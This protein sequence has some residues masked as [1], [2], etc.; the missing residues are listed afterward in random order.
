MFKKI[1]LFFVLVLFSNCVDIITE[2][3]IDSNTMTTLN[4]TLEKKTY[5]YITLAVSDVAGTL[6]F[7]LTDKNYTL[8]YNHLKAC[9]TGDNPKLDKTINDCDWDE[10]TPYE[11][12]DNNPKDYYYKKNYLPHIEKKYLIV[13]YRGENE[14]GELKV[15]SSLTD[16]YQKIKKKAKEIGK[17]FLKVL[18]IFGIV[19]GC[20]VGLVIVVGIIEVIIECIKGDKGKTNSEE[21]EKPISET[22]VEIPNKD[23]E[24]L[25]NQT[26][27]ETGD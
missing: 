16:I 17:G 7:H 8:D 15:E 13:L 2:I 24:P 26:S 4:T 27:E 20:F 22:A 6:Y 25:Y 19:I 5:F 3:E 11:K 23:P 1:A 10:M 18:K 9:Y 14:D 21:V 12:S